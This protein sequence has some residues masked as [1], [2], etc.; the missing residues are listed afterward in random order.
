MKNNLTD[1]SLENCNNILI[2]ED[3]QLLSD[4]IEMMIKLLPVKDS[5]PTFQIQKAFDYEK[6]VVKILEISNQGHLNTVILDINLGKS[7]KGERKSGRE[8]GVL[9]RKHAPKTKIIVFTSHSD[10]L[11]INSILKNIN[12]EGFLI[13]DG[14]TDHNLFQEV[15]LKVINGETYYCDTVLNVMSNIKIR[16]K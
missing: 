14:R 12:P 13:K 6:A 1:K 4:A 5:L 2:V 15:I 11:E 10:E 16:N 9:I 8:L 3:N 7:K